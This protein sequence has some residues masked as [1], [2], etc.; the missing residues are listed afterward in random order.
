MLVAIPGALSSKTRG[1]SSVLCDSKP[2]DTHT[3]TPL[4][5]PHCGQAATPVHVLWLCNETNKHFPALHANDA[6]E[7]EHG[8]NL[9]FWAQGLLQL[10]NLAV[11]T[12]GAAVQAWGSWTAQDEPKLKRQEVVTIGISTTS[13]YSRP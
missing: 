9:E 7:L 4:M 13:K 3:H 10:P 12:G 1:P 2:L 6:F 5:C 11:S 8:V